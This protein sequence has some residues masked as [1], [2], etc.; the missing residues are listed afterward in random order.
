MRV[1]GLTR[2]TLA[3][4]AKGGLEVHV[5]TLSEGLVRYGHEV[6]L[7]TTPHPDGVDSDV[8]HG[9]RTYYCPSTEPARYSNLWCDESLRLMSNLHAREPFDVVWG[10]HDGALYYLKYAKKNLQIPT[11]TILQQSFLGG[12]RSQWAE[13]RNN[14]NLA[15]LFMKELPRRVYDY[16]TKDLV[17]TRRADAVI[18]PSE[19][20]ARD[21][22]REYFLGANRIFA[23]VNG[24]D[25]SR[26][27]PLREEGEVA[28]AKLGLSGSKR[29]VFTASRLIR[30]KGLHLLLR[31]FR[32]IL[33]EVPE[34]FLVIAGVGP[35]KQ[36]LVSLAEETGIAENVLFL[37][38]VSQEELPALYSTCD[39]F[40]YPTMLYESFGISVAEAMSCACP[41]VAARSGGIA[42]SIDHEVNGFL[43]SPH[44]AE[45]LIYWSVEALVNQ[46]LA[47]RVAKEARRKA[48]LELSSERMIRDALGVFESVTSVGD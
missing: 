8:N 3:H 35:A 38:Y 5:K 27:R 4:G 44:R 12:L 20:S 39:L 10:E 17:Y 23:S 19:Q 47:K 15:L 29:M 37:G 16:L 30:G 43:Y 1:C 7:V 32:T 21:A 33:R 45:E 46:E 14:K 24:V 41:V 31:A 36:Q 48:E 26:F 6:T 28:R 18:A 40:V 22:R 13:V 42:T 34:A 25:V 9:V 2:L 11:V